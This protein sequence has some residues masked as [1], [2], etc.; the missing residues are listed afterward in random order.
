MKFHKNKMGKDGIEEKDVISEDAIR[1]SVSLAAHETVQRYGSANAEYIKGYTGLDSETGQVFAK[2]LADISKYKVNEDPMYAARNIKQQAGY[3]AEVASV[4]RDN[5]ESI[6][7]GSK[8]RASRSDDLP[9]YGTNH[10]VVDRVRLLDGQVIDGSQSQMKF[11]GNRNQ[12]L[13]DIARENG[14]F[15]RYRGVVLELP[16]EQIKGDQSYLLE[17]AKRLKERAKIAAKDASKTDSVKKL[18]DEAKELEERAKSPVFQPDPAVDYCK[19]QASGARKAATEIENKAGDDSAAKEKAAKLRREADNYD[20]LAERISDSGFTTEDAIFYRKHPKIATLMDIGRTSHRAG[21]EGARFG[22]MIGGSIS[23]LQNCW[24]V[25]QGEKD[26]TGA[27]KDIGID[28]A[29]AGALGYGTGAVAS[30]LK[31]AMQQSGQQTIQQLSKT[32]APTLV[33]N[34]CLSLGGSVK[35]YVKGEIVYAQFL[36]ELGEK[37]SGMLSSSMMA[38]VGQI[39]IPI[40]VVGAAI[41]GMIGYTLSTMF[42]QS[43][44]EAARDVEVSRQDLERIR[45]IERAARESIARERAWVDEYIK[46]EIPQIEHETRFLFV[47]LESGDSDALAAS[48]NQYATL[49]GKKLQFNT[50]AEFNHFMGSNDP[51]IL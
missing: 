16:T 5:A 18:L 27:L 48:I 20:Q 13:D 50:Q 24:A 22:L 47:V 36:T 15:S 17:E 39:A 44:L 34:I 32:T 29:K 23:L 1:T 49:L 37:G 9:Q 10:T 45:A 40:P 33:I 3:S 38:A 21:M 31:G 35:R 6:I 14:K 46:K 11:V 8:V 43:A 7:S 12:L 2:G 19:N 26:A 51:L 30:A 42:Y 25:A 28:T 4:S 41:G